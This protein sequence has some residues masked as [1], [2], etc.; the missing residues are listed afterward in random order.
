[1][2]KIV[3]SLLL[4]IFIISSTS[5]AQE[6]PNQEVR[7]KKAAVFVAAKTVAENRETIKYLSTTLRDKTKLTKQTIKV[8]LENKDQLTLEQ[9]DTLKD[10]LLALKT[11]QDA[12]KDTFGDIQAYND[13]LKQARENKD[14]DSLIDIYQSIIS[15]Q[16]L[17]IAELTRLNSVLDG[18]LTNL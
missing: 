16:E 13:D 11:N 6:R 5:F 12:I 8:K 10:S 14:F 3:L 17:R 1:M 9:L 4:F 18:L 15:I 2:K 7:Q